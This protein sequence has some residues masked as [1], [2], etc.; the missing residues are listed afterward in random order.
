MRCVSLVAAYFALACSPLR[1]FDASVTPAEVT[2][3]TSSPRPP[4]TLYF[5]GADLWHKGGTVYG[6]LLWSPGGL[7]AD[8]FTLKLLL[9]TGDYRYLSGA[10]E[11][12]GADVLGSILPGYRF[13]R[14]NLEVKAFLGLDAQHHWTNPDDPANGLRGTHLGARFNI[15]VWWEPL[16]ARMMVATTL[17]GSTIGNTYGVRG[18]TGWRV[19]DSFWTGPEIETSGNDIY[20][21]YRAGVHVTS[22]RFGNYEWAFGGGYVHDNSDR[23]G[24]YGRFSLLTRR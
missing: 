14:G 1:A 23:S 5:S 18:A 6:G 22:L 10:T 2:A 4:T 19:F 21:Q 9:A 13:K 24:F 20:H 16:P 12:R 17:T 3:L 15:D 11:V 7:D 8:G